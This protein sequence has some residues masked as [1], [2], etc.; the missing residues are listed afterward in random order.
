[1]EPIESRLAQES[2]REGKV[3]FAVVG[4]LPELGCRITS[5]GRIGFIVVRREFP[6]GQRPE[7]IPA[8]AI[9]PGF[10]EVKSEGLKARTKI[11][12]GA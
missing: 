4:S 6:E 1:M 2:V 12:T 9:G 10:G 5:K 8:W 3:V 7:S 11:S